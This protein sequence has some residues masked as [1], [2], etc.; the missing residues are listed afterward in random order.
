MGPVTDFPFD[1]GPDLCLVD[2]PLGNCGSLTCIVPCPPDAALVGDA[3]LDVDA[4]EQ[5]DA[6]E[7]LGDADANESE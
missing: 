1:G 7:E 2:V 4:Q 5:G 6:R 3:G